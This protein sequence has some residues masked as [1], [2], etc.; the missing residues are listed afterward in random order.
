MALFRPFCWPVSVRMVTS[1]LAVRFPVFMRYSQTWEAPSDCPVPT[2]HMSEPGCVQVTTPVPDAS[3]CSASNPSAIWPFAAT[4]APPPPGTVTDV[5][6]PGAVT[7]TGLASVA[8]VV[9]AVFGAATIPLN[10]AVPVGVVEVGFAVAD[11][12]AAP[13]LAVPDCI[14]GS[15]IIE[16]C[17]AVPPGAAGGQD[18]VM[19]VTAVCWPPGTVT[20]AVP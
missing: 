10:V 4:S 20:R 5:T 11:P 1:A 7:V 3:V 15:A 9:A 13:E 12:E 8:F 2:N 19:D 16:T 6:V 18:R 17:G 14:A